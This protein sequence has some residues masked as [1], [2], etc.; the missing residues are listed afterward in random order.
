[1]RSAGKSWRGSSNMCEPVRSFDL[2]RNTK[3]THAE[4][5][6][7]RITIKS[8]MQQHLRNQNHAAKE[9]DA[10][11]YHHCD[12]TGE[13]IMSM[14]EV[15]TNSM[16]HQCVIDACKMHIWFLHF[17][18][19]YST[20]FASYIGYIHAFWWLLGIIHMFPNFIG[21][22]WEKPENLLFYVF[23]FQGP[24]WSPNYMKLWGNEFFHGRR[25]Q[26][27]GSATKEVRGRNRH[28]PHGQMLGPH[29]ACSFSPR[30]SNVVDLCLVGCVLT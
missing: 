24:K 1:M 10:W 12:G 3:W 6:L 19:S 9:V 25:L 20:L 16:C 7:P 14:A 22:T 30:C 13:E 8:A 27:E 17:A 5:K 11:A 29:G 21:L 4:D 28:G 18:T 2:E 26:R 23:Y 15:L